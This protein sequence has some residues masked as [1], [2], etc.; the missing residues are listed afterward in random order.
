MNEFSHYTFEE[1]N[2]FLDGRLP[3]AEAAQVESHLNTG[4]AACQGQVDWLRKTTAVMA[5]HWEAPQRA[6]RVNVQRAFRHYVPAGEEPEPVGTTGQSIP[7]FHRLFKSKMRWVTAVVAVVILFLVSG[8]YYRSWAEEVVLHSADVVEYSGLVEFQHPGSESWQ[9]L[10]HESS[11]S[12]GDRIRTGQDGGVG[13]RFFDNNITYLGA[14]TEIEIVALSIRRDGAQRIITLNQLTGQ[15]YSSGWPPDTE[16]THLAIRTPHAVIAVQAQGY[17]VLIDTSQG[18]EISVIK[19]CAEIVSYDAATQTRYRNQTGAAC[20][21]QP[22]V[23]DAP[24]A[25]IHEL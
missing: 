1:L 8:S 17:D 9:P 21:S 14:N 23:Q 7:L 15:V 3:T 19:G 18:T 13:L 22:P 16:L 4:C 24:I 12:A 25:P 6:V 2:D 11:L 20:G 5:Q 10:D